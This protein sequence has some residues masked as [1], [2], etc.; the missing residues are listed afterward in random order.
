MRVNLFPRE[1]CA[2]TM[3]R[4]KGHSINNIARLFG[5]SYSVVY[6]Y[7]TKVERFTDSMRFDLRKFPPI[8]RRRYANRQWKTLL[9]LWNQWHE[10]AESEEGKP[11]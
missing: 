6:R 10:F 9:K 3:L 7:L 11:P 4:K 2:Y 8:C 5:R 1:S